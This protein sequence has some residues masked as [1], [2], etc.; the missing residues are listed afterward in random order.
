MRVSVIVPTI[1]TRPDLLDACTDSIRRTLTSDDELLV[2]EGGTFATNCNAGAER[3]LG[4]YLVFVNDD[5][6]VDQDDWLDRL[7][8]PFADEKVGITGCRLLYPS[9]KIQ[10]AGIYFTLE[11]GLL[12]ANNRHH[13]QPSGPMDAV[14]GACLAIPRA[15]FLALDGFDPGYRN[16]LEDVDLCL[17]VRQGGYIVW[18]ENEVTLIH[19]ESASGPRRWQ[20]VRENIQKFVEE[21]NVREEGG[22]TTAVG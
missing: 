7:L 2:M 21:W 6:K 15:L 10:H 14:T 13:D 11:Y 8:A 5:C 9:G 17:R 3:A 4:D 1:N 20:W 18:Y 16:G 19:H 22:D 12:T